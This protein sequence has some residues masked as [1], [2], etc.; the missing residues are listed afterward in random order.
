MMT[1]GLLIALPH[2]AGVPIVVGLGMANIISIPHMGIA[3]GIIAALTLI[4]LFFMHNGPKKVL[5]FSLY[6]SLSLFL[7][8]TS[9]KSTDQQNTVL[10]FADVP[11]AQAYCNGDDASRN[12]SRA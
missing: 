6:A 5:P 11:G 1:V 12:R 10:G 8:F 9:L 7:H 2:A 3:L 4:A